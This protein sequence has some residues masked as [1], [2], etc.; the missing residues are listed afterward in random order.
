MWFALRCT[1]KKTT[2]ANI[3]YIPQFWTLLK[4]TH[5]LS[6]AKYIADL[7]V[8]LCNTSSQ[9]IKKQG[10][11]GDIFRDIFGKQNAT[12]EAGITIDRD[13]PCKINNK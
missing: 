10:D 3:S 12:Y 9:G 5:I 6:I 8:Y 11:M 7:L 4:I 2:V 13:L 1:E